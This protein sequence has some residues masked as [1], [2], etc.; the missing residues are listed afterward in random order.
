MAFCGFAALS[1]LSDEKSSTVKLKHFAIA[2]ALLRFYF[3]LT[4]SDWYRKPPFIPVPPRTYI[5]WRLRTAYGKYRPSWQE[6]LRDL[7]Q[8]GD[9]LR[10]F[11]E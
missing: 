6:V 11:K 8:F 2:W 10:T 5:N 9:W 1:F 3:R 4:P 7:W